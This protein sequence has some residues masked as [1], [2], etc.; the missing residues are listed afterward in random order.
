MTPYDARNT[1]HRL[2]LTARHDFHA[3][4]S[5]VVDAILAEADRA[6]YRK[7]RNANG[8]RARYFHA[9]LV[10]RAAREG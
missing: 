8:S 2:G 7:P 5:E 3:L 4:R 10:R 9:L 1:L 6:K